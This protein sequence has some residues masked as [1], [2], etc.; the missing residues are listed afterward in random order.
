MKTITEIQKKADRIIKYA[1]A[2]VEQFKGTLAL[3]PFEAFEWSNSAFEAA[4][5]IRVWGVAKSHADELTLEAAQ[6]EVNL[7]AAYP[8]QST[9]PTSNLVKQYELAAWCKVVEFLGEE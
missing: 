5:Q 1:E 9:S 8:E 7:M 2:V 3:N 6:R 4:A